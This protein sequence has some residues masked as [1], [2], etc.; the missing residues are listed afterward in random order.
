MHFFPSKYYPPTYSMIRASFSMQVTCIECCYSGE[1]LHLCHEVF[2]FFE[3]GSISPIKSC[4]IIFFRRLN[5]AYVRSFMNKTE[6]TMLT[7][8]FCSVVFS[9]RYLRHYHTR[10]SY[11]AGWEVNMAAPKSLPGKVCFLSVLRRNFFEQLKF[12]FSF[13]DSRSVCR[14]TLIDCFM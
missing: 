1:T 7:Q 10:V 9:K 6:K 12:P 2:E 14:H 4:K 8:R 13:L 11:S 5:Y 3:L